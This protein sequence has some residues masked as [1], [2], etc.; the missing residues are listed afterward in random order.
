M[1]DTKIEVKTIDEVLS[2]INANDDCEIFLPCI[3]RD[4]VWKQDRIYSLLD[5]LMRGDPMG[6]ILAWET[7][8]SIN[9]RKFECSHNDNDNSEFQVIDGNN[10][11]LKQYILDG[12][13]RLQSLYIAMHGSY[14]GNVLYFDLLDSAP[15]PLLKSPC[16]DG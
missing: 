10:S 8:R 11:T 1:P 3:Q 12:Q 5:S 6:V 9:Y 16:T 14:N 7:T 15:L 4:F 2:R 13:Q